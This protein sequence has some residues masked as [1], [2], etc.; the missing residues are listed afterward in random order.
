MDGYE[1][2]GFIL[3]TLLSP[4]VFENLGYYGCYIFQ[5][6]TN[7]V[8]FLYILLLVEEPHSKVRKKGHV[9]LI[10]AKILSQICYHWVRV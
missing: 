7:I 2:V 9:S 8:A 4:Y 6:V 3:G 10:G 1:L 5:G